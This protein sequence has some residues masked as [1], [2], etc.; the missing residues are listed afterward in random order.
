MAAAYV[1]YREAAMPKPASRA[2]E[3]TRVVRPAM[4]ER[5]AHANEQRAV[6]PAV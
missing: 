5:V 4:R 2:D 1:N 3:N 6:N